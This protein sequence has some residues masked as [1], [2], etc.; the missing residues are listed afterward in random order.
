MSVLP[1]RRRR[2]GCLPRGAGDRMGHSTVRVALEQQQKLCIARLYVE[3][4]YG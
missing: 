3:G 1:S 2:L 4:R